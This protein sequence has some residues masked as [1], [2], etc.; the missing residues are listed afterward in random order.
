[1]KRLNFAAALLLAA[2]ASLAQDI[3]HGRLLYETHCSGCHAE[4]LHER[5]HSRVASLADLRRE[6]E[7]WTKASARH[8][9]AAE[10]EALVSYLD[11]VHYRLDSRPPAT[12]APAT[13]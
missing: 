9:T 5:A 2:Q 3:E 7:R 13:Q 4:R 10:R 6:V 11:A 12:P 1:M 8:F